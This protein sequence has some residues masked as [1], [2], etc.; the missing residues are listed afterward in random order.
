MSQFNLYYSHEAGVYPIFIFLSAL[1]LYFFLFICNKP[2][3]KHA[4]L[5]LVLTNILL[6]YAHYLGFFVIA[7]EIFSMFFAANFRIIYKKLILVFLVLIVSYIPNL[8]IFFQ[9]FTESVQHGTWVRRPE[10][11][12][13]YGNLNRFLNSRW[14]MLVFIICTVVNVSVILQKKQ[15]KVKVQTFFK[16]TYSRIIIIW[17][18]FPYCAMFALSFLAPMFLDRYI[19]YISVSFYML[20]AVLMSKFNANRVLKYISFFS[21]LTAMMWN[22][23]L[24]PDNNRR[25]DELVQTINELKSKDPNL[26]LII[27]PEYSALEFVYHYNNE[28]FKDYTNTYSLLNKDHIYPLRDFNGFDKSKLKNRK[29]VYLDCGTDFA[30]GKNPI[31]TELKAGRKEDSTIYVYSIYTLHCFGKDKLDGK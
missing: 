9:R 30:F 28:Y 21:I 8:I 23:S 4:Y 16:S 31:L 15:F 14:V 17:F 3:K 20:M 29:V 24:I 25:V 18:V 22:F 7:T 10:F 26:M 19:I 12:E 11:T 27:S 2:H 5:G 1:S 13:L 6:V